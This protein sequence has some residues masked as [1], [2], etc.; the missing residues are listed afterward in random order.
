MMPSP[1]LPRALMPP[2]ARPVAATGPHLAA[3]TQQ[4]TSAQALSVDD[5]IQQEN[6]LTAFGVTRKEELPKGVLAVL[7][8][9]AQYNKTQDPSNLN[10]YLPRRK[11]LSGRPEALRQYDALVEKIL[12]RGRFWKTSDPLEIGIYNSQ[13]YQV[14]P[15]S[16]LSAKYL[17]AAQVVEMLDQRPDLVDLLLGRP[18]T[19]RPSD[20]REPL[21]FLISV[22]PQPGQSA[23]VL[24]GENMLLLDNKDWMN[25]LAQW[26]ENPV[27]ADH[28]P[29][30]HELTHLLDFDGADFDGFLFDMSREDRQ[31]FQMAR[32]RLFAQY[33][34]RLKAL[35][36]SVPRSER[37][38]PVLLRDA[39]LGMDPYLFANKNE[40]LAEIVRNF[41]MH[42]ERLLSPASEVL[43]PPYLL[44]R[45]RAAFPDGNQARE[46]LNT[47]YQLL[48][49]Y[50][51]RDKFQLIPIKSSPIIPI[52]PPIV[53]PIL[54][55]VD[56]PISPPILPPTG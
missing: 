41:Q 17:A 25:S 21:Q 15:A 38:N 8:A 52:L 56:P 7:A 14:R 22:A 55:P 39:A 47:L 4:A 5:I 26:G 28:A 37:N 23:Y 3:V 27:S 34:E 12:Q 45:E 29:L 1:L 24:G 48:A 13:D 36:R 9:R 54:P 32:D 16:D 30:I 6:L 50:F 43:T 20:R 2:M 51:K 40:F 35:K 19:G 44:A 33:P 49:K 42:S 18:Q 31:R 10:A 46:D 53:P 11:G